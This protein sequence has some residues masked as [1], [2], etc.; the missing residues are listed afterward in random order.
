ME[1]RTKEFR[2]IFKSTSIVGGSQVLSILLGIIKTKALALLL[3]PT[4]VGTLGIYQSII[5]LIRNGS[6]LGINFSGVRDVAESHSTNDEIQISKAVTTLRWWAWVTGIFGL[7]VCISFS[8]FISFYSFKDYNHI[9]EISLLS[10]VLLFTSISASQLALLQ[11][12][13]KLKQMA[14][15]NLLGAFFSLVFSIVSFWYFGIHGIVISL[16][17]SSLISLIMSYLFTRHIN[18]VKIEIKHKEVFYH[19][20]GMVKMGFFIVL[21]G[22]LMSITLYAVRAFILS[23]T[24]MDEVGFFQSSWVISTT[25]INII[26]FSMLA[27]FYPKLSSIYLD[28]EAS[29]RLISQQIEMAVLIGMPLVLT[30][31][32]FCDIVI[33][34]LYSKSFNIGLDVLV[35]QLSVSLF[36]ILTWALGVVFL[37]KRSGISIIITDSTW[38][39]IYL[40]SI[41]FGWDT[42]GYNVL[43][44][45]FIV[46]HLVKFTLIVPLVNKSIGF[47]F[48]R[49]EAR[50]L[51]FFLLL[52]GLLLFSHYTFESTL[53]YTFNSVIVIISLG[54]SMHKLDKKLNVLNTI[55]MK[56]FRE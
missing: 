10:I 29:Q 5:D 56:F 11:G 32:A 47:R 22:F 7:L 23:K 18:L 50:E 15:A 4:G 39:L 48:A 14:T 16:I 6:G 34:L 38:C 52:T 44:Y 43:G 36:V 8:T 19:G 26:L 28:K 24:G 1:G 17:A 35:L 49:Q 21:S 46:A 20:L 41:Y 25:Y 12:L 45:G 37:A 9:I 30:L 55:R 53:R 51:I 42:W 27:D 13:R 31:I 40:G 3:G 54:V 2:Q 33:T